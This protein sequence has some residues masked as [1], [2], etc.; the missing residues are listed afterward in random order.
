MPDRRK[1]LPTDQWVQAD[2]GAQPCIMGF[3]PWIPRAARD[4]SC[5]LWDSQGAS[6]SHSHSSGEEETEMLLGQ[7]AGRLRRQGWGEALGGVCSGW[8]GKK[9]AQRSIQGFL[10]QAAAPVGLA[11]PC[12][13][14]L[15][16]QTA[17]GWVP[18]AVALHCFVK[19]PF[20][21]FTAWE[22]IISRLQLPKA[23]PWR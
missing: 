17:Q 14:S 18:I 11:P 13:P 7:A 19:N 5:V 16:P 15:P 20:I 2:L 22:A 12:R 3:Q 10:L 6:T 4:S 9:W 8:R 1:H 23:L 21:V